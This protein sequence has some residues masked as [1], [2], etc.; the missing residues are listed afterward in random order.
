MKDCIDKIKVGDWLR[1]K[2]R[3]GSKNYLTKVIGVFNGEPDFFSIKLKIDESFPDGLP[4]D[5]FFW[6]KDEYKNLFTT[7]I[8]PHS[9]LDKIIGII[10]APSSAHLKKRVKA[11][12]KMKPKKKDDLARR[13]SIDNKS[14]FNLNLCTY[15]RRGISSYK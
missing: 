11:L 1:I 5:W 7:R 3:Y 8:Y 6:L 2:H 14:F 13:A 10:K 4:D 15:K 12:R 9:H